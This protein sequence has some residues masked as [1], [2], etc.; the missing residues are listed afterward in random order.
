MLIDNAHDL[1]FLSGHGREVADMCTESELE[2]IARSI[3]ACRE[4][5][6]IDIIGIEVDCGGY[7]PCIGGI[8]IGIVEPVDCLAVIAVPHPAIPLIVAYSVG[9]DNSEGVES[10]R[11]IEGLEIGRLY[12]CADKH[13]SRIVRIAFSIGSDGVDFILAQKHLA[14]RSVGERR[15]SQSVGNGDAV[16]SADNLISN[17]GC[18]VVTAALAARRSAPAQCSDIAARRH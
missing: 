14:G 4:R 13:R 7:E 18:I 5:Q 15:R 10:L 17:A 8:V 1:A 11:R 12:G 9:V 3:T 16:G 6:A 2:E